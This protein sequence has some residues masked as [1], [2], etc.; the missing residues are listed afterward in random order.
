MLQRL[1]V[2]VYVFIYFF[3]AE[4]VY[5]ANPLLVSNYDS[6]VTSQLSSLDSQ[7]TVEVEAF[8][9]AVIGLADA[10]D[11]FKST[12][13]ELEQALL[14]AQQSGEN[15]DYRNV[16]IINVRFK[17]HQQKVER[18]QKRVEKRQRNIL[19]LRKKIASAEE[20][21]AKLGTPPRPRRVAVQPVV[22][23]QQPNK[24]ALL[25]KRSAGLVEPA[26]SSQWK[27]IK[28]KMERQPADWPHLSKAR[29]VDID[30]AAERLKSNFER[31]RAGKIDEAPLNDVEITVSPSLG[32]ATLEYI[33]DDLFTTVQPLSSGLQ[34]FKVFD[35]EEWHTIPDTDHNIPYRIIFDITSI[36]QPRLVL[37]R[38]D[39]VTK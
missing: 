23:L 29:D 1:K 38:E 13:A 36:T 3:L 19:S 11:S 39:L 5:A 6:K 18:Y 7:L 22:K 8:Q 25:V 33:G 10:E 2:T 37:F 15:A 20:R 31:K 34:L 30:Y 9:R 24:K 17:R 28:A 21:L 27:R 4:S 35:L 12:A 16:R 26:Q 14:A 32:K